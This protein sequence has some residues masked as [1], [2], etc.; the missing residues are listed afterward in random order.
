MTAGSLRVI[1]SCPSCSNSIGLAC[2]QVASQ[3]ASL[4]LDESK[5]TAA[6][7]ST[8]EPPFRVVIGHSMGALAA[9]AYAASLDPKSTL[10]VLV[11]PAILVP[12]AEA[13]VEKQKAPWALAESRLGGVAV[14]LVRSVRN[15]ARAAF[16]RLGLPLLN[17]GL[18]FLLRSLA[19]SEDFWRK[20]LA[21][22]V[23]PASPKSPNLTVAT[24]GFGGAGSSASAATA[25]GGKLE[26]ATTTM[27]PISSEDTTLVAA[28]PRTE[29]PR[30]RPPSDAM[31]RAYRWPSLCQG[32]SLGLTR[33]TA[34][35]LAESSGS[36][37]SS[38]SGGSSASDV[39]VLKRL[40]SAVSQGLPVL[41]VHGACDKVIPASNSRFL[42][43][44][45]SAAAAVDDDGTPRPD[46][47]L[48]P[49][50]QGDNVH[51]VEFDSS[52]HLPHEEEPLAFAD[53]VAGFVAKMQREP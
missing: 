6:A 11:S 25:V 27:P 19:Y 9:S 28:S 38:G 51:L 17:F 35:A 45:L 12:K 2:V 3:L 41:V 1:A 5:D 31:V 50:A 24:A 43:E 30:E 14:K 26:A 7:A 4:V 10:L 49:S 36:S 13:N 42:A 47:P 16:L 18:P 22:A 34:A 20:G 53:A 37:S 52:G 40:E 44:R 48:L 21:S 32:W 15:M 23:G 39:G 29:Q 33:F 46:S 8:E